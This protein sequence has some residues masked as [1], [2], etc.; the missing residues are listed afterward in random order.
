MTATLRL[1]AV[2][3]AS[4]FLLPPSARAQSLAQRVAS[5]PDGPVQFH[6]AARPGVCGNGRTYYSING[7]SWHGTVN[8]NTFR[9]DPCQP[10]PVRVLLGRAGQEIVDVNTY[11]GPVQSTPGATDLG[12]VSAREAA[13]YL[14]SLAARLDG[15]PGRDAIAPAMLGDSTRVSPQLLAIARD[16]SRARETRSSAIS[17]LSR[18]F[19]EPGGVSASDLARALGAIARD[20]T[21]NQH[22]RQS[23]LRVLSRQENGEGIP[24]LIEISR[25]TQDI[26]LGKA[27]LSTLAQSGDPRARSYLRTA[28]QR[29]DL[30][31]DMKVAAIRGIGRDYATSQDAEFLRGLYPKLTSEKTKEAVLSSL[32]EMGGSANAKWL[33]SIATSAD[34]PIRARRRA[35]QLSDRAGTSVADLTQLYDR[36]EDTQMK[37]AVISTLARNGTKPALDKLLAIARTDANYSLRRRAVNALG[38]SDD[39]RIKEALKEIVERQ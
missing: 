5:A 39:P 8:D 18:A 30:N 7:T 13:D 4:V 20:E 3:A 9:S 35:V 28:V 15:R 11:V 33:M 31:D 38:R 21:D 14:I 12:T 25:S 26:W 23:A 1:A 19:E 17:W 36:V 6:Y 22:V 32:G 29:E 34:E 16:Q 24:A 27:A 10:G 37:D 2:A